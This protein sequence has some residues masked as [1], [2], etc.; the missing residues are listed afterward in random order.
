MLNHLIY[1]NNIIVIYV[2]FDVFLNDDIYSHIKY[3]HLVIKIETLTTRPK[4]LTNPSECKSSKV[5]HFNK[6]LYIT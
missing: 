3:L 1:T 6:Q 5:I 4:I 2:T